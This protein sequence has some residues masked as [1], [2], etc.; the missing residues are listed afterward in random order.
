[1]TNNQNQDNFEKGRVGEDIVCLGFRMRGYE[2][3]RV[4]IEHTDWVHGY[5]DLENL[6]KDALFTQ[7]RKSPDF[8][9]IKNGKQYFIEVKFRSATGA[10]ESNDFACGLASTYLGRD[11]DNPDYKTQNYFDYKYRIGQKYLGLYKNI[12][13]LLLTSNYA[14][15]GKLSDFFKSQPI[16]RRCTIKDK[17]ILVSCAGTAIN[18][19]WKNAWKEPNDLRNDVEWIQGNFYKNFCQDTL[20]QWLAKFT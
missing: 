19:D 3:Y 12:N 9:V 13:L 11:V 16:K 17:S 5:K 15:I 1:M 20:P 10:E 6:K 2:I 14:K 7:M 4:G 8:M 18:P